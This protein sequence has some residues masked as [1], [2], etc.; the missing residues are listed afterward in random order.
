MRIQKEFKKLNKTCLVV[1]KKIT[2][3]SKITYV[4]KLTIYH[5]NSR[6]ER[7]YADY[8]ISIMT[9]N[10]N[11]RAHFK[12]KS[13]LPGQMQ[14]VEMTLYKCQFCSEPHQLQSS[15]SCDTH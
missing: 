10:F 5:I 13:N 11:C 7:E 9:K 15:S 2:C 3:I 4:T 14:C 12:E 1:L 8:G 6:N